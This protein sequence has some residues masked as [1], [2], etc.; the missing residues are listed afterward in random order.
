[1]ILS[2]IVIFPL[3]WL[4]GSFLL[5]PPYSKRDNVNPPAISDEL[6]LHLNLNLIIVL[7]SVCVCVGASHLISQKM[8]VY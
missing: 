5:M 3:D 8:S 7:K 6:L 4:Q 1:M 2:N